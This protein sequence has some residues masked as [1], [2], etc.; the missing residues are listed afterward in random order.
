MNKKT[1]E[2]ETGSQH[3]KAL[4]KHFLKLSSHGKNSRALIVD[5]LLTKPKDR[6]FEDIILIKEVLREFQYFKKL[7]IGDE[8]LIICKN[9]YLK[10]LRNNQILF[11]K[12]DKSDA[13]YIVLKGAIDVVLTENYDEDLPKIYQQNV[14]YCF[15]F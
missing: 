15:F 13:A 7:I 3:L 4:E 11:R 5:L 6:N 8:F 9:I 12:G 2:S 14:S 1:Q 10:E